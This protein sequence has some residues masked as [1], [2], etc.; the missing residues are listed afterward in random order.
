MQ[1]FWKIVYNIAINAYGRS[2]K[3]IRFWSPKA[4][5]WTKGRYAIQNQLL[6]LPKNKP[7]IW[8]HA[9]SVGEF[10]Q[11]LPI[12][13]ALK[14]QLPNYAFLISFFS[15]SG[16]NQYVNQNLADAVCY[17]P[18]D[19]RKSIAL[20]IEQVQPKAF[21][22][23]KYEFW[24]NLFEQLH[25]KQIPIF[26]ISANFRPQQ[27]FFKGV[28]QRFWQK[29][30][31]YVSY[32]YV[33]NQRSADLLNKISLTN[34]LISHDTRFDRVLALKNEDFNNG[35]VGKFTANSLVLV[36]GSTWPADERFLRQLMEFMPA[37]FKL[38]IAPHE[39]GD[40]AAER[41]TQTFGKHQT[42]IW[43]HDNFTVPEHC[44]VLVIN[45]LGLL[46]KVYRYGDFA[47][48]GGGLHH[49]IH[50]ILE[51]AVYGIPI[52]FGPK[53]HKFD[54]AHDLLAAN[55]AFATNK[56]AETAKWFLNQYKQADLFKNNSMAY[57]KE[58][59]GATQKIVE[60]L[61]SWLA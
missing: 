8:L 29:L 6:P 13:S 60:H 26:V 9:S 18:L 53:Y 10:E 54:E 41:I 22:V 1:T 56:P 47:W 17:L 34:H 16:F 28:T 42:S 55:L 30:L 24:F 61:Q 14:K 45:R 21:L 40:R 50:N 23:V 46:S 27:P 38:L 35:L 52:A 51:P 15:P 2:I 43:E 49:E 57:F 32:F 4:N 44:N 11:G 33:Q 5:E 20:F 36:A 31:K 12:L 25:Q 39:V 3:L 58:H 37:N 7:V 48:I 59:A 19:R